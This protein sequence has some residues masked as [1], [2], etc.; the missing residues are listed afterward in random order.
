MV[1]RNQRYNRQ[2][3]HMRRLDSPN[4]HKA[5]LFRVPSCNC[6]QLP[7][8]Q[9]LASRLIFDLKCYQQKK[10]FGVDKTRMLQIQII[11][12]CHTKGNGCDP[13]LL[14]LI[15]SSSPVPSVSMLGW[16]FFFFLFFFPLFC[17]VFWG[18]LGEA[19]SSS[20]RRTGSCSLAV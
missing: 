3:Q 14:A 9:A 13:F 4:S 11:P 20:S 17:F 2:I 8:L 18:F 10:H 5:T 1:L 12:L 6:R 16:V 7:L 15:N 19:E